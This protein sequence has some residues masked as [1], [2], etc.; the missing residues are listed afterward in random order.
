MLCRP[1]QIKGRFGGTHQVTRSCFHS[2]FLI[3]LFL[4]PENAEA[5]VLLPFNRPRGA[6]YV[7]Q[8]S[9]L[10]PGVHVPRAKTY[11]GCVKLEEKYYFLI[12]TEFLC[13]L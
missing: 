4:D 2:D 8:S 11:Y 3:G 10:Q 5:A 1:S 12:N 9:G 7:F 6:I 13:R